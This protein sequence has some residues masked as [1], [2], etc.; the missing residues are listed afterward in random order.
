VTAAL[1]ADFIVLLHLGFIL[2]VAFGGLLVPRWPR[3]AWVHLPAVAWGALIELAGSIICP[4][5]PW[6]NA[7]RTAAGES[8][9]AG[10][11]VDHYIVPLVYPPGLTRS[12]QAALGVLVLAVNGLAYGAL[13]LR[14]RRAGRA[15]R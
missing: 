4:L 13:V 14:L 9:Y 10:G 15:P 1:A 6:E 12:M 7:L 2:F 11:F 5:T 8:G 3:L